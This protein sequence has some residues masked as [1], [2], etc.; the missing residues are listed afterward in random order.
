MRARGSGR[1]VHCSSILGIVPY[2]W[3][4]AYNAT[5][6]ALEALAST[7]RM[8]LR[9][10]GITVSLIEPGPIESRFSDNA[11]AKFLD[12]VD[13]EKSVH[14]DTYKSHLAKLQDGGGVNRFRL[15]PEA[16]YLKLR[17]A[18]NARRPHAHYPV[19]FPTHV[20]FLARRLLPQRWLDRLLMRY[21]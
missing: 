1:I 3:R 4:G 17:H 11:L 8:E 6:F 14:R 21:D 7:Q 9:G 2:R 10:S 12:N 20:M 13:V 5:K 18:L 15:G 16:V 19:T